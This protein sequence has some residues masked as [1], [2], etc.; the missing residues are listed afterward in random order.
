MNRWSPLLSVTFLFL[1]DSGKGD[2]PPSLFLEAATG[3]MLSAP[4]VRFPDGR[5]VVLMR[6]LVEEAR[7]AD[8]AGLPSTTRW[9][10]SLTK[11]RSYPIPQPTLHS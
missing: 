1:P 10:N 11:D 9:H 7:F 5:E 8:P 3:V 2:A 4:R 6:D